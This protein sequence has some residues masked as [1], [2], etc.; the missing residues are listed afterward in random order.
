MIAFA[1]NFENIAMKKMIPTQTTLKKAEDLFGYKGL[2][3]P[4]EKKEQTV[5]GSMLF[6]GLEELLKEYEEVL[7]ID[8]WDWIKIHD[9]IYWKREIKAILKPEQINYVLQATA[10]YEEHENYVENTGYFITKLI[11]NSYDAGHNKFKLNTSTL[12]KRIDY[13]GWKLKGRKGKP[14]ELL[15]EG[16]VGD[17]FC[18]WAEYVSMSIKGDIGDNFGS[19]ARYSSFNIN[20]N[21]GFLWGFSATRSIFKTSNRETFENLKRY[22][23]K[24][25]KIYFIKPDGR[26]VLK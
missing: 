20:G 19:F 8:S 14:L 9:V 23:N 3:A 18:S 13:I 11:Q 2:K 7:E 26:E 1:T 4:E 17:W 24:E 5:E 16:D 15:V 21:L 12:T 25:N 10:K 6:E 22:R